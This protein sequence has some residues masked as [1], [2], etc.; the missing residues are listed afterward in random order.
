[1][2]IIVLDAWFMPKEEAL[3]LEPRL[4]PGLEIEELELEEPMLKE[5]LN[6]GSEF[7]LEL[8]PDFTLE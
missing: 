1:M 8:N 3:I 4:D 7:E 5:A 6:P 2:L